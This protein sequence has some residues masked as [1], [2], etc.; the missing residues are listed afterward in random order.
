MPFLDLWTCSI[1]AQRVS[2]PLVLSPTQAEEAPAEA[3]PSCPP[4]PGA[5]PSFPAA[6]LKMSKFRALSTAS[7]HSF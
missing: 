1:Q 3:E 5:G 6:A 7:A 4:S 2:K